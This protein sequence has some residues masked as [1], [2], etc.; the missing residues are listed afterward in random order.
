MLRWSNLILYENSIGAT[1]A[2]LGLGLE[3]P[4]L[5]IEETNNNVFFT[6]I[7]DIFY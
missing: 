1:D 6:M 7:N 3:S 5:Y 4:M 2:D